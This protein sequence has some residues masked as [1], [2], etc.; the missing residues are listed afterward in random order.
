[1]IDDYLEKIKWLF[2][3][4]YNENLDKIMETVYNNPVDHYLNEKKSMFIRDRFSWFLDLDTDNRKIVLQAA[5]D[6]YI[7]LQP[8]LDRQAAIDNM[9][10]K[11]E[12][13]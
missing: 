11:N 10:R 1:M 3:Y 5:I 2:W 7:V 12:S 8:A 6:K 13:N 4:L 9:R